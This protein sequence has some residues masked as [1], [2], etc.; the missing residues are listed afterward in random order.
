[1][2]TKGERGYINKAF[3]I[4]RYNTTYKINNNVLPYSTRNN[5][6]YLVINSN[7]KEYEKGYIYKYINI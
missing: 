5:I 6:Q 2:V 7:R 4:N 1:M 3:G